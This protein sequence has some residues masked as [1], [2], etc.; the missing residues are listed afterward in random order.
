MSKETELAWAAGIFEGEGTI[1]S[2][3]PN[4]KAIHIKLAITQNGGAEARA[5]LQRFASAVGMGN[6]RG[7]YDYRGQNSLGKK[8]RNTLAYQSRASVEHVMSLLRPYLTEDCPKLKKYED[9]LRLNSEQADVRYSVDP[10]TGH[11]CRFP[12]GERIRVDV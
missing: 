3:S 8:P 7:P 2:N 10:E 6:V 4:G 9:L 12:I 11:L 1:S 5:L